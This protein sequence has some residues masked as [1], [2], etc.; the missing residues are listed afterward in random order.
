MLVLL[1]QKV[2]LE[3]SEPRVNLVLQVQWEL[4]AHWV[5]QAC[6]EKEAESDQLVLWENV[7]HLDMSANQVLWVQW[8]SL[9]YLVFPVVQE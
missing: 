4:Q 5:Q 6:R 8:E 7:V 9:E 1:G 3:R 2:N